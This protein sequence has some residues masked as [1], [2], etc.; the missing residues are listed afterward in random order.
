M[1]LRYFSKDSLPDQRNSLGTN[2]EATSKTLQ[3]II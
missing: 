3:Y 1:D 2:I